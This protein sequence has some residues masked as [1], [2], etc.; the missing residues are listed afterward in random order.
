MSRIEP[1]PHQVEAL[2][3]L[4]RAFA[5]HERV[6]L[7]QACGTG[8]TLI[9]RWHSEASDA[10]TVLVLVPSLA[11]LAQT[12]REWRR[13][14][15]WPFQALVVCS[16]PTTSTGV[17]ER[18]TSLDEDAGTAAEPDW[19]TVRAG[20]TTD[21]TVAARFLRKG[22]PDR[23]QVVF[24][25]YHSALV[26][27]AAQAAAGVAFDLVICDEAHRLTGTP[28]AE[29]RAV[30]EPRT[31]AA[32]RRLFMTATPRTVT[33]EGAYSM[34]D[35]KTFGVL[36]HTV[37]FGD[38]I[39]AGLLTDYQVLVIAGR[40]QDPVDE[41][42]S[43]SAVPAAVFDAIDTH[44]VR[45]VLSF[46]GRI[47]KAAHFAEVL[48]GARTPGGHQ[49][50]AR[51]VHGGMPT[52]ARTATLEWLGDRDAGQVRVVSNA[53]VLTEGID[54]PAIDAVC[55]A[56]ER[57][58]VVDIIQAIGRV[59]RPC[60][61]KR[62]GTIIVPITLPAAGDDDT[63]LL[64]SR[65]GVLWSVLRGLRA[66]DQRFAHELDAAVRSH[67]QH[68][69]LGGYRPARIHYRL[70]GGV[71]EDF[72]HLRV[73]Q[74]LGDAWER[75][76]AACE[77]WSWRHP[78]TRLPR[79]T[80]HQGQQVGKWAAK[81]RSAHLRG[82][83]PAERARRLEGVPGWFWDRA[84]AAWDDTFSVLQAFAA[85]YG[86]VAESDSAPS[87][88]EGMR[89]AA[90]HRELLGQWVA[91]QR[92]AYRDG[93]L[94]P[95]RAELL[96]ELAGWTWAP[97]PE[98]DLAMVDALRQFVE[99]EH[100]ADV[101]TGHVE[102]GLPLGRWVWDVRRR[103]LTGTL[104][105]A[106]EDEIWVATPSRWSKGVRRRWQWDKPETQWRLAYA[107]LR[108]FTTRED[109]ANPPTVH[110]EQLP[111]IRVS[112]GQWVALQ[113]HDYRHGRLDAA[114]AA[115]LAALPGWEWDGDVGGT[116]EFEEPLELPAHVKHGSSGAL[117]RRCHCEVCV[118]AAR[119]YQRE[120][121][122]RRRSTVVDGTDA[123]TARRRLVELEDQ[124]A[125]VIATDSDN[126]QRPGAGR[127][128][129]AAVSGVP[130]GVLRGVASGRLPQ[131]SRE[132]E[133][134]LRA[135][136]A[137]MCLSQRTDQGSRGRGRNRG[138]ERIDATPTW[139]IIRT[140]QQRN[141]TLGW[142][143]R[144]LGYVGGLQLDPDRITRRVAEQVR[145]LTGRIGDLRLPE[146][147]KNHTMLT[148][149]QL[150]AAA[151]SKEVA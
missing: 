77:D 57:S 30:L 59:L 51:H 130:L 80:V 56:D 35:P 70:P 62:I 140:L 18:A 143:G 83:L 50:V 128:L 10:T 129:V 9:G 48:D 65:F 39:A 73:V 76:F 29:F 100:T 36:A 93:T 132:H 46:H 88:F 135:T 49:V 124:L 66:H 42:K 22:R 89:A 101:P 133:A 75:Y 87:V 53:R 34:D 139:Q 150:R 54:V 4:V 127:T 92:Q 28:R 27:A 125:A 74:D 71:N 67:A 23:P 90:P 126:N 21:S 95:A 104:H 105:P 103:K 19:A 144:E 40:A 13:A 151:E 107:A 41:S 99:F 47:A 142:I 134:R 147:P 63:G 68:G 81:Q 102:D 8:K 145:E 118:L 123:A 108:Q 6:Q 24:S 16:D 96:E 58:S 52:A 12:L 44:G 5:L 114:R 38:A 117:A 69:H 137:Q 61:G 31:I 119:T 3:D 94:D 141:F 85:A 7:V 106:L 2:A 55:F 60:P 11:L 111:D 78:S 64:L 17:A 1:R 112:L 136:T 149:S 37:T 15:G 43:A 121:K 110:R 82:L 45:R 91:F 115:A 131:V 148:L 14:A 116:R 79:N 109:H 98:L 122:A 25:T 20:V 146:V 32:R 120:W 86:S 84:D 113:R 72:L 33:T 97:V 138:S 26:V